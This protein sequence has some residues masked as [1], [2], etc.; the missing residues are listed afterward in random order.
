MSVAKKWPAETIDWKDPAR[1]LYGCKLCPKCGSKYRA[2]FKKR[3]RLLIECSDCGLK[4]PAT[5]EGD[6]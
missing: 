1:N 3:G 6:Q 5:V 2:G 4:V